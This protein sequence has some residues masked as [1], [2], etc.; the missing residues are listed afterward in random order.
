[1]S[2]IPCQMAAELVQRH[3][4]NI[5]R[6]IKKGTL[7]GYPDARGV[8]HVETSEL[9]RVFAHAAKDITAA[10]CALS[11]IDDG[12]D[13]ATALDATACDKQA[14]TD[15]DK[16]ALL[17]SAIE[18]LTAQVVDVQVSLQQLQF[19]RP[20]K[21]QQTQGWWN[22]IWHKLHA[23]SAGHGLERDSKTVKN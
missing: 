5:Y 3:R 1:M 21:V 10:V 17:L 12:D 11:Q 20:T 13:S 14:N 22:R 2:R 23:N 19:E 7:K 16:I 18:Q 9:V 4:S 15:T 6:L 8:V